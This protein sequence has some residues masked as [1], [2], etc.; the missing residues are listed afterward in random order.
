MG[1]VIGSNEFKEEYVNEKIQKWVT[2]IEELSRIAEDEHEAAL[3]SFKKAISHR[4]TYVQR[5]IPNISHLFAPLKDAKDQV[6]YSFAG[7]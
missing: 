7:E 1:A 6:N 2:D 4:W 3:S 5:T